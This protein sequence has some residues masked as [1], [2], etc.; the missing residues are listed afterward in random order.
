MLTKFKTDGEEE[1][2]QGWVKDNK[3][4][5]DPH[6][7]FPDYDM[8]GY[9]QDKKRGRCPQKPIR[10]ISKYITPIHIKLRML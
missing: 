2:F 7:P 6:D 10:M 3:I 5:F 4:Q 8:R 9:Y 1:K